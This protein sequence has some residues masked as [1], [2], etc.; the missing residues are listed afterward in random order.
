MV[1]LLDPVEECVVNLNPHT[2]SNSSKI[3]KSRV[4]RVT[5]VLAAVVSTIREEAEAL[6]GA[7]GR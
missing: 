1:N 2:R 4:D 5:G 7:V 3:F 6:E